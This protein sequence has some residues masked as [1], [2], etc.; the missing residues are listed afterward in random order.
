MALYLRQQPG[1]MISGQNLDQEHDSLRF[2]QSQMWMSPMLV[3]ASWKTF[4]LG[5]SASRLCFL[6]R[7]QEHNFPEKII[8]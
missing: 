1:L 6:P 8:E 3:Q 5:R 7:G 2:C 4:W